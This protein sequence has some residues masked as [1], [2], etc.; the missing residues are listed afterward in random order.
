[1]SAQRASTLTRRACLASHFDPQER[2]QPCVPRHDRAVSFSRLS[3]SFSPYLLLAAPLRRLSP[4]T[5]QATRPTQPQATEF[6]R[7]QAAFAPCVRRF[8]RQTLLPEMT[9][10]TL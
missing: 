1:M 7:R 3:F 8:R 6:A 2:Y 4:L 10:S 5:A 9:R